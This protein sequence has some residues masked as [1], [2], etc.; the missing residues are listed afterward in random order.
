MSSFWKLFRKALY[1]T[2]ILCLMAGLTQCSAPPPAPFWR[3]QRWGVAGH[4]DVT[5]LSDIGGSSEF[6]VWS[7]DGT[8]IAFQ[9]TGVRSGPYDSSALRDIYVMNSDGTGGYRLTYEAEKGHSCKHP[10]W[11]PDSRRLVSACDSD[12]DYDLYI[13]DVS[14]ATRSR[15]TDF[16]G[17]EQHPVWSPDG[18]QIAF[19]S[20]GMDAEASREGEWMIYVI[21]SDGTNLKRATMGPWDAQPAWSPDNQRLLFSS[22]KN[23]TSS[24]QLCSVK[25][26]G[27]NLIC[28]SS[29]QCDSISASPVDSRIACAWGNQIIAIQVDGGE[30]TTLL[31]VDVG[32]FSGLSWSPDGSQI[33]FTAGTIPF[34]ANDLY[35]LEVEP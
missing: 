11:A 24:N 17:S 13:L 30:T 12:G 33:V 19:V 14:T 5:L 7:P 8:Q 26:Y 2:L 31:Q 27:T 10:S 20:T 25:S 3:G 6:P 1:H 34:V 22:Q 15:L 9:H 18:S 16:P 21:T 23:A 35:V 29:V 32:G 4:D 28:N